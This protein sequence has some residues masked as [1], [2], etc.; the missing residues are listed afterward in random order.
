MLVEYCLSKISLFNAHGTEPRG[1]MRGVALFA[2]GLLWAFTAGL[3]WAFAMLCGTQIAAPMQR[4]RLRFSGASDLSECPATPV[5]LRRCGRLKS[6]TAVFAT[7]TA[8]LSALTVTSFAQ[9]ETQLLVGNLDKE[10]NADL[11]YSTTTDFGQTFTVGTGG[12]DWIVEETAVDM[13]VWPN[14]ATLDMELWTA[15]GNA[16][17]EKVGSFTSPGAG[18]GNQ[19][20]VADGTLVVKAGKSYFV[21]F[22]GGGSGTI[23]F[24]GTTDEGENDS[25]LSNWSMGNTAWHRIE[26]TWYSLGPNLRMAVRGSRFGIGAET[27]SRVPLRHNGSDFEVRVRFS[28]TLKSSRTKVEGAF[29]ATGGTIIHVG[30]TTKKGNAPEGAEDWLVT[31]SPDGTEAV[32]LSLATGGLCDESDQVCSKSDEPVTSW[33]DAT[34]SHFDQGI[35]ASVI[36]AP[37]FHDGSRKF[38]VRVRFDA[39]LS[40]SSGRVADA[41]R[42]I[43]TGGTVTKARRKSNGSTPSGQQDWEIT[44]QPDGNGDVVVQLPTGGTCDAHRQV[45]AKDGRWI[46]DWT[47]HAVPVLTDGVTATVVDPPASHDGSN[48]FKVR[49][50]FSKVLRNSAAKVAQAFSA[51]NGTV[52][53]AR[54][55]RDSN[56]PSG[57]QDW[58]VT[59]DPDG[60]SDVTLSIKTGGP[61]SATGQPCSKDGEWITEASDFPLT[62][63]GPSGGKLV[64]GSSAASTVSQL[65]PNHP[66]PFNSTTQIT[67]RLAI[68]GPVW[69]A[70]FNVLGQSV[71]TLVDQVQAVGSYQVS[72][73]GRDQRGSKVSAGVY[74]MRLHYPDGVQ[75]RRLLYLK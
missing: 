61:C 34:I 73:D 18:T 27:V 12:G 68:P 44:V 28:K 38:K 8:A 7:V 26:T 29:S 23:R 1:F 55:A 63:A 70:I 25:S 54:R 72:W 65:D 31:L 14:T 22:Q 50:R 49:V 21:R 51:I 40:N 33:T 2:A 9:D 42:S 4:L 45:C 69:L 75:T 66:N 46:T 5:K 59:I 17:D 62:I 53:K 6:W 19:T 20:W 36:S 15:N 41:F 11:N 10:A 52:V 64:A 32:T 24:N 35:T 48:G 71:R 13:D 3:L 39:E 67:Y 74:L 47:D 16:P 58:D 56:A 60:N 57:Q 43:T 30:R 37:E